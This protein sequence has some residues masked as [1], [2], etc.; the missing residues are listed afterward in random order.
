MNFQNQVT[1]FGIEI[2][3]QAE[4]TI[5]RIKISDCIFKLKI[6]DLN[7]SFQIQVNILKNQFSILK[8]KYHFLEFQISFF[9]NSNINFEIEISNFEYQTKG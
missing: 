6:L 9:W 3:F 2:T 1:T 8:F 4:I 7:N 5:F